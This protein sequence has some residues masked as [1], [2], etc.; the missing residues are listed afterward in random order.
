[1]DPEKSR[2]TRSSIPT[3]ISVGETKEFHS[4]A[5]FLQIAQTMV[6]S[7]PSSIWTTWVGDR[8]LDRSCVHREP[9][10]PA[11][12]SATT[13]KGQDSGVRALACE[14]DL[15][16]VKSTLHT[17]AP[18]SSRSHSLIDP[19]GHSSIFRPWITAI[20][21]HRL[22]RFRRREHVAFRC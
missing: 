6:V 8:C 3:G 1:M 20:Q 21:T 16:S 4:S 12:A 11:A 10:T 17:V 2:S 13:T 19:L 18:P 15:Y 7:T 22:N 9:P 5:I 14:P